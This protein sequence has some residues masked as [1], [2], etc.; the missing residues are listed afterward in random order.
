MWLFNYL[1]QGS[2][3]SP[4]LWTSGGG[5]RGWYCVRGR[6][7]FSSIC[8][9]IECART[10]LTQIE[11]RTRSLAVCSAQF[12]WNVVQYWAMARGLGTLDLNGQYGHN[13]VRE[14]S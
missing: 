5:E 8:T 9:S 7:A 14:Q 4:A 3:T 2:P 10:L 11:F 12:Q 13:P 1:N 6:R